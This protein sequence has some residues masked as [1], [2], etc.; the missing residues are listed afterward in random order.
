MA[1]AKRDKNM[2]VTLLGVSNADGIT[3]VVLWADPVTHRLLVSAASS[4]HSML[5]A[6]HDDS[7][8]GTVVLGDIIIGNSTPKWERLA[9]NIA[10]TKKFLIQTG[11]GTISAAPSWG[12]IIAADIPDISAT[13]ALT[14][15]NHDLVYVPLTRTVAGKALS[16][17][18]TLALDDLSDVII[19]VPALDQILRYNG[20]NWY[21]GIGVS[22]S[23]GPGVHFFYDDTEIIAAGAGPQTIPLYTIGKTPV[24][25]A[26]EIDTVV[27]SS[28]D[29]YPKLLEIYLYNTALGLTQ[30][31]AGAWEFFTYNYVDNTSGTTTM[32]KTIYKVM[33]GAGTVTI[34]G[35]GTSR[36]ATITGGTP[37]LSTDDN[38]DP[39]LA[40]YLQTPNGIFQITGYTS[41][42]EVTIATLS[43]YTNESGAAYSVH[44]FLFTCA[45][46]EINGTV[47]PT[48]PTITE[49]VQS[50]FTIAATDK[51]SIA[52]FGK[53]T[54]GSNITISF[55]HNGTVHNSH[56]STPIASLHNDMVGLQGGTSNEFYHLTSAE[57][58]ALNGLTASEIVGTNA[59]GNLVS[60]PVASYP[61]LTELAYVKGVTSAIQT[62][63]G[64]MLLKS[65]GTMTG[66]IV[67][68]GTTEVGKTYAPATGAQTVALD[69]A[70]N[71]IHVVS[72]HA[73]G[74]AIT[75]T[76]ANAT[77][78][79]P[80]I[81]S[82]L[83][84]GTTVSTITAWFATVR[85]AGGSAPTLTAT[86]NKRDTF[87]FIR[88]GADT[89]DGFIIGQNC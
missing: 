10:T 82:I 19:A 23:S 66:K 38:A 3:P 37:F 11:N 33:A 74:T 13:Y 29:T 53:T 26:E 20:T 1:E 57:Y 31:D 52:L 85:W 30:I 73:D 40:G 80:F 45:G 51:L 28:S 72:G 42:S 50:A 4:A 34:T 55:I 62:Q 47:A 22:V 17:D 86:L 36:T 63:L 12:T 7:V 8:V 16:S 9:G 6:S 64:T 78:S 67:K 87:G 14:G 68:A 84:G 41:T 25:T 15:H 2:I 77:S 83:Q 61:S 35:T 71:N 44:R 76:V 46:G 69:C 70:V 59:S 88:T 48:S 27:V 60:L 79:Q 43:T 21:N 56:F 18:I 24:T 65:G 54:S 32:P 58:T 49:C 89:Y 39:S 81:V 75:F 5:S